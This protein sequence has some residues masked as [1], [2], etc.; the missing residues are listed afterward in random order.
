MS[1]NRRARGP[2]FEMPGLPAGSSL[3]TARVSGRMQT[4]WALLSPSHIR[5]LRMLGEEG[6]G[7]PRRH[8]EGLSGG[9]GEGT[10]SGW[11][12]KAPASHLECE[13]LIS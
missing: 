3:V 10:H 13:Q 4:L 6:R 11:N 7:N 1:G 2:C 12:W 8:L 9:V 5:N